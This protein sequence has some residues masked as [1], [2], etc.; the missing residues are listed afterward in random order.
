M[1]KVTFSAAD[2]TLCCYL[3]GE[4]DHDAAQELRAAVDAEL[5]ARM[6]RL[7]VLDFSGVSFMDSSGVGLILGRMRRMQAIDGELRI[8]HPPAQI[9]RI[10]QIA[11]IKVVEEEK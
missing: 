4:I 6:P 7:L 8:L 10:L 1:A 11:N 9:R 5:A 2:G 3:Y